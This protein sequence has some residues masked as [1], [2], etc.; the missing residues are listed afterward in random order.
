M[1]NFCTRN[2]LAKELGAKLQVARLLIVIV[3]DG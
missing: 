3:E 2:V 1:D